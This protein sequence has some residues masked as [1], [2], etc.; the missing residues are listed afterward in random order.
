LITVGCASAP[1]PESSPTGTVEIKIGDL[2]PK[3]ITVYARDEVRWVKMTTAA[4]EIS[5]TEPANA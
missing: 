2:I 5:L 3:V 1:V 4:V